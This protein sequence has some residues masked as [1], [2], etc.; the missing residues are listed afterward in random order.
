MLR[1][2]PVGDTSPASEYPNGAVRAVAYS[3]EIHDLAIVT[4]DGALA[5]CSWRDPPGVI[6]DFV[7]KHSELGS[8]AFSSDR[9][10]LAATW[11]GYRSI[12]L[13]DVAHREERRGD[14]GTLE[15]DGEHELALAF[16]PDGKSLAS[17]GKR[18]TV[19][20]WDLD[21]RRMRAECFGHE[22]P[23]RS[24][25][26]HPDGRT[27]VSASFDGTIRFWDVRTGRRIRQPIPSPGG[28]ANCLAISPDGKF[29]AFPVTSRTEAPQ[30]HPDPPYSYLTTS[31]TWIRVDGWNADETKT[32][33]LKGCRDTIRQLAFS[34]DSRILASAGGASD[35]E[36][37]VKLWDMATGKQLADLKGHRRTVTCLAFSPDGKVLVSAGGRETGPGEIK[38]W[39][40]NTIPTLDPVRQ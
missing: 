18:P 26:F 17:S 39:D 8:V 30:V 2:F 29:L 11:R 13:W 28:P 36:G 24:L 16:S 12:K 31:A 15:L 19:Q 40:L 27:I 34:P 3:P 10:T 22:G 7:V 35:G 20:I 33:I 23:V 37:E 32:R 1:L 25:A 9:K 5:V 14:K 6:A 38:L 21:T 4:R